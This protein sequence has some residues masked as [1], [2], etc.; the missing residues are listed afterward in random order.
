M[1]SAPGCGR[2][3]EGRK[4]IVTKTMLKSPRRSRSWTR[5]TAS[6]AASSRI[7]AR[8]SVPGSR[9]STSIGSRRS[10]SSTGG[11]PAF[12]GYPH[13]HDGHDFP[14]TVCTSVNDEV[15]HGIPATEPCCGRA[16][17]SR[18]ISA[19]STRATTA[20]RRT[21]FPSAVI[22][23]AAQ[24]LLRVTREALELRAVEQARPGQPRLRHRPR[25]AVARR[26]RTGFRWSGSS[27]ATASARASTRSRRSRTSGAR[28]AGRG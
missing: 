7:C 10:A 18:S 11:V 9:R 1:R 21:P 4:S 27:S 8:S 14:G 22:A 15:V 16:T 13:R 25:G 6:S 12:K 26:G 5:R 3:W 19:S 2:A 17:S 28:G 24:R 23:P 20:T